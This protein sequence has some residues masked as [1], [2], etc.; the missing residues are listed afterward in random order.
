MDDSRSDRSCTAT[1]ST[2]RPACT[3]VHHLFKLQPVLKNVCVLA[4]LYEH[5]LCGSLSLEWGDRGV[6]WQGRGGCDAVSKRARR[7]QASTLSNSKSLAS[8]YCTAYAGA[9]VSRK[10]LLPAL[11]YARAD[12]CS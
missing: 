11:E 10:D 12:C 8:T 1:A 4:C 7:V 6:G 3:R 5:S 9:Y 2:R